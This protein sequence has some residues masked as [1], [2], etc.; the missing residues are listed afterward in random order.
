[1]VP[2]HNSQFSFKHN[3]FN[4]KDTDIKFFALILV[5]LK[6]IFLMDHFCLGGPYKILQ[7]VTFL[8]LRA[9]LFH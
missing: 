5:Q 6:E 3:S 2:N 1:M 9:G 4:F 8:K 7:F